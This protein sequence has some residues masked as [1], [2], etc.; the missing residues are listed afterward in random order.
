M[1]KPFT[2]HFNATKEEEGILLREFLSRKRVSKAALTDIQFYVM[3]VIAEMYPEKAAFKVA[4][5]KRYRSFDI[6]TG[7]DY[8]RKTF[9]ENHKFS[10]I[11][12]RWYEDVDS[13]RELSKK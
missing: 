3:E 9:S 2:L 1:A 8:F 7:S 5:D 12:E 11:K 6:V 13:F 10:D 4:S